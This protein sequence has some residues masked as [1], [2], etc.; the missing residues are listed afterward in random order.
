MPV[1]FPV[2]DGYDRYDTFDEYVLSAVNEWVP[3]LL[4][5]HSGQG[6]GGDRDIAVASY[7]AKIIAEVNPNAHDDLDTLMDAMRRVEPNR[8]PDED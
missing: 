2:V 3:K 4:F 5:P 8:I 7:V 6:W 1:R